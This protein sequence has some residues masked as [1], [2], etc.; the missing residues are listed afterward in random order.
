MDPGGKRLHQLGNPAMA[1]GLLEPHATVNKLCV[2]R[3]AFAY[4]LA[5]SP[6]RRRIQS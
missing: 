3:E 1:I 6:P 2:Q 4:F 5:Q